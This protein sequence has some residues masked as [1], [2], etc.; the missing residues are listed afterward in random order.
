VVSLVNPHDVLGYPAS[1]RR[2]GY[3]ASE[4][5]DLGV[6][7]PAT[8]DEDLSSKPAVHSLM[9]MGIA[10]YLGPVHSP[11]ARLDYVNF[12]A[13][14]HRLVDD[15][16]GRI[17]TALGSA[18]DPESLRSR[19][20]VVRCSDHGEM[21]LAHGGLRQKMFNVYEET[22]GVP[23]VFSNPVLFP[24][25]AQTDAIA[26]LVD[27]LPTLLALAGLEVPGDLRG[28]DLSPVLADPTV[29][30]RD[31]VHFTYDDHQAGTAMKDAPGQPN[32]I[33]AV[34]TPTAKYAVYFDPNGRARPEYELYDI[35]TDPLEVENLVDVRSGAPRSARARE[36]QREM[37]DRLNTEMAACR[38]TPSTPLSPRRS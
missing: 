13:H 32:R 22:L 16:I 38:T 29:A 28:R 15:K 20:V 11:R 19:T 18:E 37:S 12:Y 7:P 17:V 21:G 6:G 5:R 33:R 2:G 23:L 8:I 14:L 27:V 10:A 25:G 3:A 4:F 36:L 1:Y 9:R 24:T 26:S 31:A 30:V 34:R 35:D